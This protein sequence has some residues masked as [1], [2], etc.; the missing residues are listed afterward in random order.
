MSIRQATAVALRSGLRFYTRASGN[1]PAPPLA[2]RRSGSFAGTVAAAIFGVSASSP[3]CF[4]CAAAANDSLSASKHR[5]DF[6]IL[7]L[8]EGRNVK[9]WSVGLSDEPEE[10]S[11]KVLQIVLRVA[12]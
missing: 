10:R 8:D 6:L 2:L 3:A 12:P 9:L 11:A 1:V 5:C 4:V 7:G